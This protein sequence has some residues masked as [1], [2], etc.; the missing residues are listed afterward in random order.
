MFYLL[1][2][3]LQHS[4]HFSSIPTKKEEKW[5]FSPLDKYM[6]KA[7]KKVSSKSARI[8]D[9]PK[10]DY[11]IYLKD[12]N[13]LELELP[14]SVHMKH[15][16]LT[17]EL[18]CFEDIEVS[19]YHDYSEQTFVDFNINIIIQEHVKVSLYH[20][21][22]GGEK[23][24]ILHSSHIKLEPYAMLSQTQ[25]QD[26]SNEAVFI[27][28]NKIHSDKNSRF[29]DFSLLRNGE[30]IH[31]LFHID[32]HYHSLAD[33]TSLLLSN[34]EQRSIFSCDINHL[35]D[36]SKSQVL[37]RQVIRDKSVC[38]F[39]ANTMIASVTKGT[40]A[41][42][43]SHALLL[44]ESAQIHAKPHLEIYS[45]DLSASH[46]T[47]VG[48]LNK[49]AIS[50]LR[51]RG[52][53]EAKSKEILISAFINDTLDNIDHIRHKELIMKLIGGDNE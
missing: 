8:P 53:S 10:E 5:R 17:L 42:Q 34:K 50:Y 9:K 36:R 39:D 41:K 15:G 48:E 49:E 4:S 20:S 44:D 38:V 47:T 25:V 12:A 30:Y 18:N 27:L 40:E 11:W 33:I 31:N 28:Q 6:E 16:L 46:G 26:F 19:L 21:Y 3:L 37:S 24:F 23:S 7:Y 45:D 14:P 22:E 43:A 2:D 51:S 52:L 29:K 13:V 32:L 1:H 35:A